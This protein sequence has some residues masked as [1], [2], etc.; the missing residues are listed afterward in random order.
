MA[1]P[2]L[3]DFFLVG[4]TALALQIGHRVS[5]D[6]DLFTIKDFDENG[7]LTTLEKQYNFNQTYQDKNTLKGEI[8]GI[9]VDL[10]S[11]AYPSIKPLVVNEDN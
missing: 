7:M 10:I 5:I 4:G 2:S 3:S 9:K 11:H 6:I 1:D 8:D